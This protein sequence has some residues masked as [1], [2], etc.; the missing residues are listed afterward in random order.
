MQNTASATY[1]KGKKQKQKPFVFQVH[2]G[3]SQQVQVLSVVFHSEEETCR[4]N[5]QHEKPVRK[6]HWTP[7]LTS[8]S[9]VIC[10]SETLFSCFRCTFARISSIFFC[11]CTHE[12]PSSQ[13]CRPDFNGTS[14]RLFVRRHVNQ[15]RC[16]ASQTH[17]WR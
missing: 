12:T 1:E 2:E 11:S 4:Q 7:T 17:R 13:R 15:P 6:L 5:I 9:T 10:R 14:Q 16:A 3:F 8:R